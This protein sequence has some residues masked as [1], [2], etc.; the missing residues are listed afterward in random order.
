[1]EVIITDTV[2]FIRD[3][4]GELL[5]AFKSTLEELDEAD[6]L[7]HVIDISNPAFPQHIRVVEGLLKDLELDKIPCLKVFNKIDLIGVEEAAN[8]ARQYDAVPL[9]AINPETFDR[10]LEKAQRMITKK[11]F[12]QTD[13]GWR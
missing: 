11:M 10:F 2:G 8:L 4:P 7:V 6:L 13:A 3:L 9:S 5:Q 12:E 1:M